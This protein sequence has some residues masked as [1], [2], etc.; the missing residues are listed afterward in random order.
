[1]EIPLVILSGFLTLPTAQC[2]CLCERE[3]T[4]IKSVMTFP[5]LAPIP[6]KN[7]PSFGPG[8]ADGN[9]SKV[10]SEKHR[11]EK[12]EGEGAEENFN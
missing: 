12:E 7:R 4:P 8:S 3:T 10:K 2:V 9:D 5:L 1:M 6:L 11:G